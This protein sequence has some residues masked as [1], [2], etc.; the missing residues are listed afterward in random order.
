MTGLQV[1]ETSG[2]AR[3]FRTL[4]TCTLLTTAH[5]NCTGQHHGAPIIT[6]LGTCS[7]CLHSDHTWARRQHADHLPRLGWRPLPLSGWLFISLASVLQ[8]QLCCTQ[9]ADGHRYRACHSSGMASP[10]HLAANHPLAR[11]DCRV[12]LAAHHGFGRN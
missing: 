10:W 11:V 5:L 12:A 9:V 1:T 6:P 7:R 2:T 8:S 4:F 3:D